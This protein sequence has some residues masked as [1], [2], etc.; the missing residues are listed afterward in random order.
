MLFRSGPYPFQKYGL[1]DGRMAQVGADATEVP[2]QGGRI[3]PGVGRERAS[4]TLAFRGLVDLAA[5]E[6]LS[7]SRQSH[8]L[9]VGMQVTAEIRLGERSVLEYLLSP[10]QAAV[11]EA[12]RER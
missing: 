4:G 10:V 8:A 6:L 11:L 1:L 2:G 3:D 5:Q 12:A 7:A 9:A